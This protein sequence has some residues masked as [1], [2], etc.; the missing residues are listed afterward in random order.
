MCVCGANFINRL[1]SCSS[2]R[3][4]MRDLWKRKGNDLHRCLFTWSL[5]CEKRKQQ[6]MKNDANCQL[7][8]TEHLARGTIDTCVFLCLTLRQMIY[9]CL[10]W[11]SSTRP[12]RDSS[13]VH[14]SARSLAGVAQEGK[15]LLVGVALTCIWVL[16]PQFWHYRR[17]HLGFFEA[18]VTVL[19]QESEA[20]EGTDWI[21]LRTQGH[22]GSDLC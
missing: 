9:S 19:G 11:W 21:C 22:H 12:S 15:G 8:F 20:S 13:S 14:L 5:F 3:I 1:L 16:Q 17:C 4:K 6:R 7:C 18:E 2:Q 10:Y